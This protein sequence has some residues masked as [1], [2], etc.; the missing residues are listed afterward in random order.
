M[1]PMNRRLFFGAA[2]VSAASLSTLSNAAES[3]AGS[4]KLVGLAG[5]LRKG[6]STYK[7]VELAL[8][9]AKTV[10]P[11]IAT[12]LI[13]LSGLNLDPYIAVGAKSSD[14]PDDFPALR[15]KLVAPDVFGILMGS[16]VYMGIVSSPLKALFE[17]MLAFSSGRLPVAQ[18]SGRRHRRRGGAEHRGGVGP[19]ATDHVHAVAGDD[20]R[21]RRQA[22]QSLGRHHAV[23]R[24]RPLE[25][26]GQPEHR[27]RRRQARRRGRAA[28]RHVGEIAIGANLR[29]FHPTPFP[30]TAARSPH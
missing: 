27:P 9:S 28:H 6:K 14:R 11:A 18:Q 19:A 16:P 1:N 30:A 13:E 29:Q 4:V 26:R 15:E 12:E 20:P 21:R 25:G 10:S 8:E 5:S 7:A 22:G 24:R 17:R 23:A 2:A 3:A